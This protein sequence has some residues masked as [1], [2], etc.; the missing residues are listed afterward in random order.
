MK[1]QIYKFVEAAIARL[2]GKPYVLDRDI[3]L[4]GC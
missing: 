1:E 3:P 4:A 2:K